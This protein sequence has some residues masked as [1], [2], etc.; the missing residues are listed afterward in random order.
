MV[1]ASCSVLGMI[2]ASEDIAENKTVGAS[3]LMELMVWSENKQLVRDMRW[4]E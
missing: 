4:S 1:K 2:L 3:A